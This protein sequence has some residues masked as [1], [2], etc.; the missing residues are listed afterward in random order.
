MV[1]FYN[2]TL[3]DDKNS[4]KLFNELIAFMVLIHNFSVTDPENFAP[5]QISKI[6][7]PLFETALLAKNIGF[8]WLKSPGSSADLHNQ[9]REWLV[10]SLRRSA[11]PWSEKHK[12]RLKSIPSWG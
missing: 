7:D 2:T 6:P 12:T 3:G 9:P 5:I 10:S 1:L 11:R 4:K 8:G